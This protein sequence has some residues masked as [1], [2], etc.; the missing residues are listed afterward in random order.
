MRG[1]AVLKVVLAHVAGQWAALVGLP[2]VVPFLGFDVVKGLQLGPGGVFL[3]FFLSGYLLT[4]VEEGRKERG[5]YRM[6]SYFARR[7]LR[8]LPAYYLALAV[9]WLLWP[10]ETTGWDLLTH[11]FFVH[12][13]FPETTAS[14]D[15]VMWSLASEVAWYLI[16][17]FVIVLVPRWWQ[18]ALLL[19]GL[20][21]GGRAIYVHAMAATPGPEG[22]LY[23]NHLPTTH[24]YLFAGGMLLAML[25]GRF[26]ERP[27]LATALTPP[28]AV[29][30]FGYPY[31]G[32]EVAA[33]IHV[34]A[35]LLVD[36]SM[37]AFFFAAVAG[38]RI[39]RPVLSFAPFRFVGTISYSL[40]LLHQ[41]VLVLLASSWSAEFEA[42]ATSSPWLAFSC[43][44][45]AILALSI[46][47]AYL[48]HRFV[49]R[50]FLE[51]KPK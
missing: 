9:V 34:P 8:I 5:P 46:P 35:W 30:L 2:L 6:R 24:L 19:V 12:T 26:G 43:A 10:K 3:F 16:L 44:L 47:V 18:R 38:S 49:E 22:E 1:L 39:L 21:V 4:R 11:A 17:P 42:W 50:P 33:A 45:A 32:A 37:A 13:L 14:A 7:A 31:F 48:S 20:L 23:A 15:P 51:R 25:V 36:L 27:A 41:T 29:Y 40:F 28:A